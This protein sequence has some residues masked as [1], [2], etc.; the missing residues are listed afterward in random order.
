MYQL[1]QL[2]HFYCMILKIDGV[3]LMPGKALEIPRRGL[4]HLH[5]GSVADE[6]SF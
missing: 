6:T 3:Q 1:F 5:L 4:H 2:F